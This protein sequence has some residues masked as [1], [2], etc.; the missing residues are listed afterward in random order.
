MG[1]PWRN[2]TSQH[3]WIGG[4]CIPDTL[5]QVCLSGQVRHSGLVGYKVLILF[6]IVWWWSL[7]GPEIFSFMRNVF[8]FSFGYPRVVLFWSIPPSICKNT[9]AFVRMTIFS[10]D[11]CV[12]FSTLFRRGLVVYPPPLIL[13]APGGLVAYYTV[14][15]SF[16][17][18]DGEKVSG[19][20]HSWHWRSSFVTARGMS[21]TVAVVLLIHLFVLL[22]AS[23][24]HLRLFSTRT[25]CFFY[26]P[27]VLNCDLQI[28]TSVL[29]P[30]YYSHRRCNSS[31]CGSPLCRF[32][33]SDCLLCSWCRLT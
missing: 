16:I 12:S 18:R 3:A 26:C 13:Q 20:L 9:A 2:K 6:G 19:Q 17:I 7:S 11:V 27:F 23:S 29:F 28:Y 24:R 30:L 8:G 32:R 33:P 10:A 15:F 14:F 4:V 21:L 25:G 1:E 5:L 22:L 31:H